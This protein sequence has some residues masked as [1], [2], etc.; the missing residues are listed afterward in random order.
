V[1]ARYEFAEAE[2]PGLEARLQSFLDRQGL[3]G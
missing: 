1:R 3:G 2:D